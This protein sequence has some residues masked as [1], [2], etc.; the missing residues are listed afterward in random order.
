MNA[1][2]RITASEE[3]AAVLHAIDLLIQSYEDQASMGLQPE[4]SDVAAARSLRMRLAC[5]ATVALSPSERAELEM[6]LSV[7]G[8]RDGPGARVLARLDRGCA[9]AS[10]IAA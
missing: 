7:Y 4:A 3:A 6:A 9:D 10:S 5:C 8:G 1:T 2:I